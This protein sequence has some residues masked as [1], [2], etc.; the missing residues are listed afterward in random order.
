MKFISPVS[1]KGGS[2]FILCLLCCLGLFLR[3]ATLSFAGSTETS[4]RVKQVASYQN[5]KGAIEEANSLKARGFEAY[6][7]KVEIPEKGLWYRVFVVQNEQG[8]KKPGTLEKRKRSPGKVPPTKDPAVRQADGVTP[9]S[10]QQE[11][12]IQ[13]REIKGSPERLQ[14]ILKK[15]IV[16]AA[17]KG[18][19][20][21][22][23]ER[24]EIREK[25]KGK[26]ETER[27]SRSGSPEP[28]R[29][30]PA[31]AEFE[32]GHYERAAA[33]LTALLAQ[34]ANDAALHENS[35]RGLADCY[36]HLAGTGDRNSNARAVAIYKNIL[37]YYPDPRTG[38][39]LAYFRL[40]GFLERE[41][42]DEEAYLAYENLA[43]KYPESAH[44]P[45]ALF[46]LGEI[47]CRTKRFNHATA[48]L[49]SYLAKY[50]DGHHASLSRF[51]LGYCLRQ[52]NAQAD[53]ALWYRN[54]L[55]RENN[56][57][58]LPAEVLYDLGVF[59]FSHQEYARAAEF[60]SFCLNLYPE[61]VSKKSAMLY[62]GRSFYA[63]QQ[64]P[65]ALKIFSLLLESYP[66]TV[67]ANES[68]LFLA[69]IGVL[70]PSIDVNVCLAGW[71]YYRNPME[72]YDWM[73]RRYPGGRL[74]EWLRYQKGYALWKAGRFQE[75]F[76]LYRRLLEDFR[77][78]ALEGKSKAYLLANAK[79]LIE[80]AYGKGQDLAVADL[81]YK[82]ENHVA[83]SPEF[84]DLF[85]KAGISLQRLGLITETDKAGER[86]EH[87]GGKEPSWETAG[88]PG[89]QGGIG[90]AG[91]KVAVEKGNDVPKE[92]IRA[93]GSDADRE[94]KEMAD[95]LSRKAADPA[96]AER[97]VRAV[98]E[99]SGD[100]FWSKVASYR[101]D[102]AV[103]RKS[104]A[105]YLK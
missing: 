35:L 39:D 102:D 33:L 32:A 47:L 57:E 19:P 28:L 71:E 8:S 100:P 27:S 44:A 67:E 16:S 14:A 58:L 69:N 34:K 92:G 56:V 66:E 91:A 25:D 75:S 96:L 63:L 54:A 30:E 70:K 98:R 65:S 55:N 78:G 97:G 23:P 93:K 29:H 51:L 77:H 104:N 52:V 36:N 64:F 26:D 40:A 83:S 68:I 1:H 59:L 6:Y 50:P 81:Y 82:L 12:A 79:R 5:I 101:A 86:L 85:R 4:R 74:E 95:T 45:D 90:K 84:S 73:R 99:E 80:D 42:K 7:E 48:K 17:E 103:W 20:A 11:P 18:K 94:G 2:F 24:K 21:P 62:L 43:Q 38:N 72:T 49:S 9:P 88:L 89:G 46:K 87:S 105:D 41:G 15:G 53:G 31:R 22:S 37:H 10:P 76:D 13:K 3:T 60:F 61:E